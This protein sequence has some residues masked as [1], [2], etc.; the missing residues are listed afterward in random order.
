MDSNTQCQN[1]EVEVDNAEGASNSM[2]CDANKVTPAP[3]SSPNHR[4]WMVH[5]DPA[6]DIALQSWDQT[7]EKIKMNFLLPNYQPNQQVDIMMEADAIT[8]RKFGQKRAFYKA[9]FAGYCKPNKLKYSI[10]GSIL[11]VLAEKDSNFR[12]LW[13][14]L[15]YDEIAKN[16]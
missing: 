16:C 8:I 2:D 5:S 11:H 13:E 12:F 1:L 15:F 14:N 4:W 3:P 10:T 6:H 9:N 7:K